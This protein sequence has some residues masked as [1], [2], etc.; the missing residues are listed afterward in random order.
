MNKFDLIINAL[1]SAYEDIPGWVEKVNEALYAVRELQ[2]INAELL[3]ALKTL[4][5][6]NVTYWSEDGEAR[7]NFG[8]QQK[9]MEA[10]RLARAAIAKAEGSK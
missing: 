8:S 5:D 2:V 4:A 9:A 1:H 10:F 6:R 3:E 7:S